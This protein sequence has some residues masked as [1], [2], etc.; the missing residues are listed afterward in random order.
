[1]FDI[2][3]IGSATRDIFYITNKGDILTDPKDPSRTLIAFEF[4]TKIP[5][6]MLHIKDG[7][8]GCNTGTAFARLGFQVKAILRVGADEMGRTVI[9]KFSGE[10]GDISAI[11]EDRGLLTG[12]SAIII[13]KNSGERTVLF[14]PGANL[15]L[16]LDDLSVLDGTK[17]LYI[18]PL[19]AEKP[20]RKLPEVCK[21]A[22]SKGVSIAFNPS[23][24]E[25]EKGYESNKEILDCAKVLLVN[26]KEAKALVSS[27]VEKAVDYEPP[28]LL[29]HLD[30][31]GPEIS[32]ITLSGLGSVAISNGEYFTQRPV[33]AHVVDTTGAGDSFGSTFTAGLMMG[34]E[35]QDSL[36]LA[37]IN[38]ASVI[39]QYGAQEGLLLLEQL[40]QRMVEPA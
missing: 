10:G 17:W 33:A 22:D 39:S 27:Y 1:M 3:T 38:S 21:Y 9:D 31:M 20:V 8:G 18:A 15:N 36:K 11:S 12:L 24:K 34:Y 40:K 35:I 26:R 14:Y 37:S 28:E 4:G 25:I 7:G 29:A 23:M 16:C 2:I 13:D 5:I 32:V 6:E 19:S 30:K